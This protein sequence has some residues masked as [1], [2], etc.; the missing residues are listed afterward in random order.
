MEKG[1]IVALITPLKED[2]RIDTGSLE[3]LIEWIL[4][5]GIKGVFVGGTIGEGLALRDSEKKT[6][7]RESVRCVRGRIPVLANVSEISTNR[8]V[9]LTKMANDSGVDIVV[10]TARLCFPQ[11]T[12]G[13]T[14]RH[15]ETIARHSTVP[16]WF[17]ENPSATNIVSSFEVLSEIAALP[18]VE[19]LKFTTPDKELFTR[20]V[21]ELQPRC[22]VLTGNVSDTAYAASV[23]GFGAVSGIG[24]LFPGLSEK[25]FQLARAGRKKEAEVLQEALIS[26]YTIYGG[27][28]MP[29]WPAAQKYVL[30][31]RGV[32]KNAFVT[33]PFLQLGPAEELVIEKALAQI[34]ESLF[35]IKAV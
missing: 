31:R 2:E 14:R 20:C 19:G 17:Y 1:V 34:D 23:G 5:G 12:Q 22:Y 30:K 29:F 32:I 6:L 7:F 18:A 15:V 8:S 28:G 27:T 25:T 16:V 26:A 9:D 11:R 4:S 21:K 13:E 3:S 24:N 33:N 35:K 10:T